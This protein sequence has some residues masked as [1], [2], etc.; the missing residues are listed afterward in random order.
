MGIN[1]NNKVV[2][3]TG[4]TIGIGKVICR[5]FLENNASVVFT[6]RHKDEGLMVESEFRKKFNN[7]MYVNCDASNED[8]I[9]NL[10]E[11]TINNYSKIDVLVNNAAVVIDK[12]MDECSSDEF[13]FL[14]KVNLRGYFLMC[15]YTIPYLIKTKGNIVNNSSICGEVGQYRKT[16]YSATKGGITAFTKSVA[17]DYAKFSVRANT[18]LPGAV[19]TKDIYEDIKR[20][21]VDY[22]KEFID[23]IPKLQPL[24]RVMVTSEEVANT[25]LF[26]ASDM[27]SGITGTEIIIDR[28][29]TLDLS[30]GMFDF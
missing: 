28:G 11:E 1:F 25:I 20:K 4:G 13:D 17:L 21:N 18:V 12:M 27:A 14:Y 22:S 24:G 19:Y 7:C 30:P 26:L 6:S 29:A 9:K 5:T 8:D 16:L 15:K 3:V 23:S 10:I 2:I